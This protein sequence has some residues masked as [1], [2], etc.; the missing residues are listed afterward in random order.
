MLN[1]QEGKKLVGDH[2]FL[3]LGFSFLKLSLSEDCWRAQ[4][5]MSYKHDQVLKQKN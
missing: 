3:S 1:A 2:S 4:A 5:T